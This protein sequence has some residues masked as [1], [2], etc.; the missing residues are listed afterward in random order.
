MGTLFLD[1]HWINDLLLGNNEGVITKASLKTNFSR[2]GRAVKIGSR[3]IRVLRF[4]RLTRLSRI[5]KLYKIKQK[6]DENFSKKKQNLLSQKTVTR[7]VYA[8][9]AFALKENSGKNNN[10]NNNFNA[11][12]FNYI[13]NVENFNNT[14]N[15]NF[16]NGNNNN[17]KNNYGGNGNENVSSNVNENS[18]GSETKVARKLSDLILTRVILMILFMIFGIILFD[19][20]FYFKAQSSME[21]GMKIF[22]EFPDYNSPLVNLTFNIYVQEHSVNFIFS[23]FVNDYN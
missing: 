20:G 14:N 9:N 10:F 11:Y 7:G 5:S 2:F 16:M 8:N 1:V 13:P 22:N 23:F 19:P 18:Q 6:L 4:L 12:N 17:V 15:K 21:Y 3:A